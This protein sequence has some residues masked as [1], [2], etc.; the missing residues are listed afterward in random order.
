MSLLASR[1]EAAEPPSVNSVKAAQFWNPSE[2]WLQS[3]AQS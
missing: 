3:P 2:I 1:A